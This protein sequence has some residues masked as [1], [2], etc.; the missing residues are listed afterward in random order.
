MG[1]IAQHE[2]SSMR[3][4]IKV[5]PGG[6]RIIGPAAMS[7]IFKPCGPQPK[8]LPNGSNLGPNCGMLD[9]SWGQV[10]ANWVQVGPKLGPCWPMLTPS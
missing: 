2:V 5:K 10:G 8:V 3:W 6:W 1:N 4:E 9:R 7:H